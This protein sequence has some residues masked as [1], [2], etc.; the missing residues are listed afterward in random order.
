MPFGNRKIYFRGFFFSSVLSQLKE[1]HP[2]GNL[3]FNYLGIFQS[4]KLR[5]LKEKI[6]S[7]SLKLN[8]TP[9]TLGCSGFKN[10]LLKSGKKKVF[11][12]HSAHRPDVVF[13]FPYCILNEWPNHNRVLYC[14]YLVAG[15]KAFGP[16]LAGPRRY[17]SSLGKLEFETRRGTNG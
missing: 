15:L 12:P 16:G 9:N 1:Y 2:S 6:L 10:R 14:H 8:F 7:I 13:R 3:K 5:Y 4:L 11:T 17:T